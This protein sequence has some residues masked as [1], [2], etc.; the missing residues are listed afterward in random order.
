MSPETRASNESP[1]HFLISAAPIAPVDRVMLI[2]EAPVFPFV[3]VI[4]TSV[5]VYDEGN[6]GTRIVA[7]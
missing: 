5:P 2:V 7:V 3:N 1:S 6:V 4:L